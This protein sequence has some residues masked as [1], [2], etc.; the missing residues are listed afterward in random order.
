MLPKNGQRANQKSKAVASL[1]NKERVVVI[2]VNNECLVLGV[3]D[4][5]I[6]A[7]TPIPGCT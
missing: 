5:K 7:S 6:S 1:G 2:E 4:T 3:T